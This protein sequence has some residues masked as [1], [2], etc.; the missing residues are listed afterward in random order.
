MKNGST[1]RG[2]FRREY[3]IS[4]FPE[5]LLTG[6]EPP[7]ADTA[8]AFLHERG[9]LA[10]FDSIVGYTCNKIILQ[11]SRGRNKRKENRSSCRASG[12]FRH[13]QREDSL[14]SLFNMKKRDCEK[15]EIAYSCSQFLVMKNEEI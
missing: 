13:D 4:Y 10:V 11:C 7:A 6:S 14:E 3:S 2:L 15:P 8:S 12:V 5:M 9:D 1:R